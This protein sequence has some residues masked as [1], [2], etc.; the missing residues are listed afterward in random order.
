MYLTCLYPN[1]KIGMN[2]TEVDMA[3]QDKNQALHST[4]GMHYN[5]LHCAV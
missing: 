2:T 5:T 3:S 1:A 4:S